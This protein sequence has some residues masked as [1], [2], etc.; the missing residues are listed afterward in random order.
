MTLLVFIPLLLAFA[1]AHP[2][3]KLVL[4]KSD[5]ANAFRL[6][7]IHPLWQ[8]KQIVTSGMPTKDEVKKNLWNFDQLRRYVDWCACFSNCGSP[9]AWASVMGLVIWIA[10]FVYNILLLCCYVDDCYSVSL[11]NDLDFYEPYSCRMPREQVI[12]LRL[13]DHLGIP[14]KAPKQLWG[15]PLAVIGFLVDPNALT[16][17][18]PLDSK[19]D[20]INHA[21]EFAASRRRTLH[22]WQQ[23]TGWMNWSFNVFPLLRPSLSNVYSK[24]SGKLQ[25]SALIYI[26]KA[27]R[28]ELEWFANHVEI[29]SGV[30]SLQPSIGICSPNPTL[31]SIATSIEWSTSSPLLAGHSVENP[32]RLTIHS[33]NMNTVNVFSS[34][35][36]QPEYNPIL[37]AAVD[38]LI[39]HNIDLR[40]VHIPGDD[41][42]TADS[43]SRFNLDSVKKNHPSIKIQ[44]FKPPGHQQGVSKNDPPEQQG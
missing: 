12:L 7:P 8:I 27:V 22:E 40:V 11:A 37:M 32:M 15:T 42:T 31:P 5:V 3:E 25:P 21:R 35:S 23:L 2:G 29:S 36:A 1:R 14:H 39:R 9:R 26:N 18:M 19:T 24:M 44:H 34:L 43:L 33:D 38:L 41:N 16:A 30:F 13:W 17:T 10:I 20:L 4:W 6:V 28:T